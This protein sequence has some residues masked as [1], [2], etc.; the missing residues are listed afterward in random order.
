M[1][2]S[3]RDPDRQANGRPPLLPRMIASACFVGYLPWAS[4]TFG[5]LAGALLYLVPGAEAPSV[6]LGLIAIGLAIGIPSAAIVARVEGHRLTRSAQAAKMAF[7]PATP[8]SPDPSSVVIDEVVGMWVT[9]LFLPK[10]LLLLSVGFV[11]FRILDILKP[12][13]ARYV[14]RFPG[15]WGIMLD[16]VVAGIY[17]NLILQVTLLA[18]RQ[19]APGFL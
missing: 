16:D 14:E 4:G 6:L 2:G 17:A 18:L 10:S 3:P 1:N 5:S 7:Q 11:L 12:E 19:I 8:G 9:L 15:G 13:P